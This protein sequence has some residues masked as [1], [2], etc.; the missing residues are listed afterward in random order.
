MKNIIGLLVFTIALT[1]TQSAMALPAFKKAFAEKYAKSHKSKEFQ[2]AVKK[3]SCN[4][5]HIKGAKKPVQNEYGKLL[6]KLI[7][8]DANKRHKAAKAKGKADG[9][10]ELKKILGELDKAFAKAADTKSAAGKGPKYAEIMKEGKLPVDPAKAEAEYKA[11]KKKEA[12]ADPDVK[13]AE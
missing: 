9:D 6:N 4:A 13:S 5:C 3:A 8:G 12:P 2:A 11:A 7:E 10:A 1:C